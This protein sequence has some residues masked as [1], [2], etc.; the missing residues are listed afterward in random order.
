VKTP[1]LDAG[2]L[3]GITRAFTMEVG[4]GIGIHCEE[5]ALKDQDLFEADE[6][7]FTSTT[8]EIVPIVLVDD[9]TIGDGQVGPITKRLLSEYRRVAYV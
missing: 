7:F 4:A 6:A 9:N 8:K 1:P 2:L 3:A 5:T